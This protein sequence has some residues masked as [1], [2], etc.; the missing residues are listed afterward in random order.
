MEAG[1]VTTSNG[2][3]GGVPG[4]A[5]VHAVGQLYLD[6]VLHDGRAGHADDEVVVRLVHVVHLLS[7][8]GLDR[9]LGGR[10]WIGGCGKVS[11]PICRYGDGALGPSRGAG[12]SCALCPPA[13][14]LTELPERTA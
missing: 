3:L 13:E 2:R 7:C 10:R 4:L 5:V 9:F 1:R 6:A 12:R 14:P 8:R 11:S